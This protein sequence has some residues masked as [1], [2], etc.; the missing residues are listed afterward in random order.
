MPCHCL[1]TWHF[2]ALHTSWRALWCDAMPLSAPEPPCLS[3]AAL[4]AHLMDSTW[5][6]WLHWLRPTVPARASS[7]RA[8]MSDANPFAAECA[9]T[10]SKFKSKHMHEPKPGTWHPCTGYGTVHLLTRSHLDQQAGEGVPA[11]YLLP[12]SGADFGPKV[13]L[14]RCDQPCAFLCL[15]SAPHGISEMA[16]HNI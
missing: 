5:L 2:L 16:M 6:G 4:L 7:T 1:P 3:L 14:V 12:C 9:R 15:F 11:P 13:G 8:S 10:F